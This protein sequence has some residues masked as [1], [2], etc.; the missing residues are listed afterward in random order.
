MR[1]M[2]CGSRRTSYPSLAYPS[3]PL[4]I[5]RASGSRG[6]V[7]RSCSS[8]SIVRPGNS[9]LLRPALTGRWRAFFTV[10]PLVLS[11]LVYPRAPS[12]P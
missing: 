11:T 4:F 12:L 1:A 7:A 3:V 8:L 10:A 6:L 9:K 5:D 2:P